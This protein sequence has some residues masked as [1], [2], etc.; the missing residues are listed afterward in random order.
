MSYGVGVGRFMDRK[1]AEISE[2][3]LDFPAAKQYKSV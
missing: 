2:A 3:F 1:S